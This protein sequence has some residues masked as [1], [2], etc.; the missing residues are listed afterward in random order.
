[1]I[2]FKLVSA[3]DLIVLESYFSRFNFGRRKR[4]IF[5]DNM[6]SQYILRCYARKSTGYYFMNIYSH[7]IK[8]DVYLHKNEF[9]QLVYEIDL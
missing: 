8:L 5:T 6:A 3:L 4:N 2:F 1:M 9:F 7:L